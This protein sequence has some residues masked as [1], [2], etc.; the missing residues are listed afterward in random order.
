MRH[1]NY[2]NV[3]KGITSALF[4]LF[5]L[6]GNN[7]LWAQEFRFERIG[8]QEGL[9][10]KSIFAGVQDNKGYIWLGTDEGLLRDD[11]YEFKAYQYDPNKK[12]SF[13]NTQILPQ[14]LQ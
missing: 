14:S 7:G 6:W 5:L 4:G 1:F 9:L 3:H 10:Q 8:E 12:V 13:V 2:L 11:G